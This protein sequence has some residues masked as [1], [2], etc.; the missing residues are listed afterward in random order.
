MEFETM[1]LHAD[2]YPFPGTWGAEYFSLLLGRDLL[3]CVGLFLLLWLLDW[4]SE[5]ARSRRRAE[6]A[7]SALAPALAFGALALFAAFGLFALWVRLPKCQYLAQG[8][9]NLSLVECGLVLA[10]GFGAGR[11]AFKR[12]SWWRR[13]VCALPPA[14]ALVFVACFYGAKPP[15]VRSFALAVAEWAAL[16]VLGALFL[17]VSTRPVW[18]RR[19]EPP[20]GGAWKA[21]V[22]RVFWLLFLAA[23]V[24]GLAPLPAVWRLA[25]ISAG[26]ACDAVSSSKFS[27]SK[28]EPANL[29]PGSFD[30]AAAIAAAKSGAEILVPPGVYP[31]IYTGGKRLVIRAVE[32]PEKTVIDASLLWEKGV[33]NRCAT[34]V[35][36][37]TDRRLSALVD[38]LQYPH[39]L[40]LRFMVPEMGAEAEFAAAA[41]RW[42]PEEPVAAA[43]RLVGFTLRKGRADLGGGALGGALENCRVEGCLAEFAGG[44]AFGSLLEDCTLAGNVAAWMGAG[45]WGGRSSGCAFEGNYVKEYGGG[46][47]GGV[48]DAPVFRGNAAEVGGACA[49]ARLSAPVFEGNRALRLEPDAFGGR[50]R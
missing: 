29:E 13:A 31:P 43:S 14:A 48:H 8:T 16:G 39:Q 28:F 9:S 50:A 22:P 11:G 34:L 23:L 32:G 12:G 3:W 33:T 36:E 20:A 24:R 46:A 37:R 25:E 19:T 27:S 30:L 35:S 38:R 21:W 18:R 26:G 1:R 47:W 42:P 5:R 44:G 15:R 17:L 6:A 4:A 7:R 45:A 2:L 40:P 41:R 10:A 49:A